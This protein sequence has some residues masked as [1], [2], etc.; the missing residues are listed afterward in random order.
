M[1]EDDIRQLDQR[2]L[3]L[4]LGTLEADIWRR[5]AARALKRQAAR[6]VAS[7]QCIVMVCALFGSIAAGISVGR[8]GRAAGAATVL[9]TGSELMPSSLLLGEH[10]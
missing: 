5:V 10:R 1:I 9:A 6:K 7:F 3:D 4:S 2:P 8:P